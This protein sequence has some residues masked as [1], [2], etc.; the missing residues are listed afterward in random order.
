[1]I[2]RVSQLVTIANLTTSGRK[3]LQNQKAELEKTP[4]IGNIIEFSD[5]SR[6]IGTF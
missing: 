4:K 2:L 3:K 5:F 1:L 6:Q